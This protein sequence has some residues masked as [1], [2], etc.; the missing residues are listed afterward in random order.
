VHLN[1]SGH[2][3]ATTGKSVFSAHGAD[4]TQQTGADCQHDEVLAHFHRQ[5]LP[6]ERIVVARIFHV[7]NAKR[8]PLSNYRQN[9]RTKAQH[10][11]NG[12]LIGQ[13]W[14]SYETVIV[15]LQFAMCEGRNRAC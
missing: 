7:L 15:L 9:A 2:Q 5:C 13:L 14:L 12:L 1:E 11:S 4:I 6:T 10:R 3:I 8:Q